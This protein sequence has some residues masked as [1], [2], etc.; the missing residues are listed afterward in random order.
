MKN[1]NII[2]NGVGGQGVITLLALIAEAA[3]I[4][5]YDVKS[6]ELHGLSQR[7]GSVETHIRFGKK[8]FS[9]LIPVGKADLII[10]LE[11]LEALR[12][13]AKSGKNTKFL[14]NEYIS[15]FQGGLTREEIKK[16]FGAIKNETHIVPASKICQ[17]KLQN[18]VVSTIY[19]LGYAANKN[20]IPIKKES[21][22]QAIKNVI[23][24]KYQE[25]NIKAFELA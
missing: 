23:P 11:M 21:F 4:E 10:S 20:L 9:P 5:G 14:V 25:L 24:V 13:T 12:E 18:E 16:Q 22:L 8:I 17:E 3:F 15:P 7:G 19:L 2:V 1:F 6:S